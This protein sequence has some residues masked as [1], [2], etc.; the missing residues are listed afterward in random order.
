MNNL[1]MQRLGQ[2]AKFDLTINKNFYRNLALVLFA[3]IFG[4]MLISFCIRW[5][6]YSIDFPMSMVNSLMITAWAVMGIISYA[7][8]IM[9]GC[10]LHPMRNKQ[11]RITHLTLPA[12]NLEKYTWHLFI[13]LAGCLVVSVLSV[14]V[15]D[16]LNFVL[17]RL[18]L[19]NVE[20][21]PS[22]TKAVF[23][24]ENFQLD[25]M[26]VSM[27]A[28]GD[29]YSAGIY[30]EADNLPEEVVIMRKIGQASWILSIAGVFFQTSLFGLGN[31]LKYKFNLPLTYIAIQVISTVLVVL[32]FI[33]NIG[34]SHANQ[35]NIDYDTTENIARNLHIIL[36]A[37]SALLV[38]AGVGIWAWAYK[39]YTKAQLTNALNK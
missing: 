6:F 28:T 14:L 5:L 13:C 10:T 21:V 20:N 23:T 17:T 39:I 29:N 18:L 33:V 37:V 9:G 3:T 31:S 15:A 30:V 25:R 11:G 32:Y 34:L 24:D 38:I 12:T 1:N 19:D 8:Y 2:Y 27:F 26:I 36:Y 35:N 22:L 7:F 4:G 16:L